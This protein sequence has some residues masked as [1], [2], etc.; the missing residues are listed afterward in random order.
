MSRVGEDYEK[1]EVLAEAELSEKVK[2]QLVKLTSPAGVWYEVWESKGPNTFVLT[3]VDETEGG[4]VLNDTTYTGEGAAHVC[5]G[6]CLA[7]A[8]GQRNFKGGE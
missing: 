4:V 2:L 7:D 6:V 8:K 1:K 5:Y 3:S